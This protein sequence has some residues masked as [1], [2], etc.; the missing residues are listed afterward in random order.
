[1]TLQLENIHSP[2]TQNITLRAH[3]KRRFQPAASIHLEMRGGGSVSEESR[4]IGGREVHRAGLDL[5]R[6]LQEGAAPCLRKLYTSW[7]LN[8]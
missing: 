8:K 4:P 2:N 5:C 7:V 1:M 3:D 6:G